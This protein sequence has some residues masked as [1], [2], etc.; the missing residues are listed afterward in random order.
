MGLFKFKV[1]DL[2]EIQEVN[3]EGE[4]ICQPIDHEWKRFE[5]AIETYLVKIISFREY[6]L[7]DKENNPTNCVKVYLDDGSYLYSC[8]SFEKFE[9]KYNTEYLP[10]IKKDN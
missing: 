4:L 9:E 8:H 10:L 5:I 7:F 3:S 6:V 1:F 2:H